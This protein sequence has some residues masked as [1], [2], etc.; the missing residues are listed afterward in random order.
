MSWI[1]SLHPG[2]AFAPVNNIALS[3][4]EGHLLYYTNMN[5]IYYPIPPSFLFQSLLRVVPFY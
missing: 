4:Q 5:T 3:E 1:A 2:G